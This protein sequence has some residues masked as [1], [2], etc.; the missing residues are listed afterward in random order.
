VL[1]VKMPASTKKAKL[2]GTRSAAILQMDSLATD[3]LGLVEKGLFV[4]P[5]MTTVK[6]MVTIPNKGGVKEEREV[7][8]V[9]AKAETEAETERQT[10]M[11]SFLTGAVDMYWRLCFDMLGKAPMTVLEE[12]FSRMHQ[13]F[14]GV[15]FDIA[16]PK[17]KTPKATTEPVP[18]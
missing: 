9:D 7:D 12:K 8:V 18:A 14:P 11:K 16:E 6:K 15:S 13:E 5:K 2:V 10:Q 3:L 1:K 4:S 17:P